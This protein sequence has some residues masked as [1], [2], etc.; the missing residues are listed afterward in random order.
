MTSPRVLLVDDEDRFRTRLA[1]MLV[2]EGLEV[3]QAAGGPEA[4]EEL[5]QQPYDVVLLDL[6]L[7]GMDGLAVMAAIKERHPEV[8][9]IVLSG[10]ASLDAAMDIIRLGGYDY[11]LKP[12]PT[13]EL[14][15]KIDA[16]FE[17]KQDRQRR[18]KRP[19]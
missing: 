6:R 17:K 11:L 13:E 2:A 19:G 10:H 4:L 5:A 1:Q 3:H 14:L 16:A 18:Q 7:P 8:E 9:V 15:L 12:C